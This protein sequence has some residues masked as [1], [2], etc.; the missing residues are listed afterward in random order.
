MK[1]NRGFLFAGLL[2]VYLYPLGAAPTPTPTPEA[3]PLPTPIPVGSIIAEADKTSEDLA[4]IQGEIANNDLTTELNKFVPR[5]TSDINDRAAETEHTLHSPARINVLQGL[6]TSWIV[7]REA[8]GPS[9]GCSGSPCPVP[10]T[11]S[12]LAK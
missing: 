10:R 7:L 4:R 8:T 5:L 11:L 9:P 3:T 2:L 6:A 12:S 1:K